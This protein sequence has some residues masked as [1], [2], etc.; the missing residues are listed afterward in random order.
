MNKFKTLINVLFSKGPREIFRLLFRKVF[1]VKINDY[2]IIKRSLQNKGGLEIGGPSWIFMDNGY[3]PL[4]GIIS[5]LD[6]CVFSS[7]TIWSDENDSDKPFHFCKNKTGKNIIQEATDLSGISDCTYDFVISS[8][9][10]EHIANP[11]K[12]LEEWLRVIKHDGH[13]L[14]AV[15]NKEKTF[16]HNRSI[17]EFRHIMADYKNNTSEND[18]THLEEILSLHDLKMDPK[19]GDYEQ[20]KQRSLSNATIRALHHHVFDTQL[21][22]NMLA[23]FNT[24]IIFT[25]SGE[26]HVIFGIKK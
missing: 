11:M 19:A 6:N 23:E 5:S 16:D 1:P 10:L 7:S 8:H 9:C 20:F 18:M 12:A 14:I 17:T 22:M 21:L 26:D 15:P 13:F 4:Y 3:I 24:E 25:Y 2:S